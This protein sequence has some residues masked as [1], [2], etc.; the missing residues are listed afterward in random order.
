MNSASDRLGNSPLPPAAGLQAD[1]STHRADI[2]SKLNPFGSRRGL[3]TL[4]RP[5]VSRLG[6]SH[7]LGRLL[8]GRH[9]FAHLSSELLE[10]VTSKRLQRALRP[11]NIRG[12]SAADLRAAAAS[13][14]SASAATVTASPPTNTPSRTHTTPPQSRLHLR[15]GSRS[16]HHLHNPVLLIAAHL[17]KHHILKPPF[18]SLAP[19]SSTL[20][21]NVGGVSHASLP[22]PALDALGLQLQRSRMSLSTLLQLSMRLD[23]TTLPSFGLFPLLV[24][25][26][27]LRVLLEI[28]P[29]LKR[30]VLNTYEI[31]Q[32][33]GSGQH[34]KVD[35]AKD[36]LTN[37][38]VAI[39][40]IDR[41]GK[42]I[43]GRTLT[44]GNTPEDKVRREIAIMKKCLHP[45]I[46][47]LR[48][49]LDDTS[50]YKV[51]LVLE[52]CEGGEIAWEKNNVG[53]PALT[54]AKARLFFRDLVLGL[55]YLHFQGIIHRDIK[56][57]NMLLHANGAVKIS[58]FGVSFLSDLDAGFNEFELAKT[59][60]TPAF[61]A[62]ELCS[63]D[64]EGGP[65]ITYK[66]DIWS[67]GVTLYC[68]L[69][70]ELPF[71]A[72]LEFLL[73]DAIASNQVQF[74]ARPSGVSPEE[75]ADA[76]SLLTLLLDKNPDTRIT[77]KGVKLHPFMLRWMLQEQWTYFT[78]CN[79]ALEEGRIAVLNEEMES[80]VLKIGSK[81]KKSL[82]RAFI[83][84]AGLTP[85][86]TATTRAQLP[87]L[88]EVTGAH[89]GRAPATPRAKSPL[90]LLGTW[91]S[92][93]GRALAFGRPSAG[94]RP[95]GPA[96]FSGRTLPV[97][98]ATRPLPFARSG[99]APPAELVSGGSSESTVSTAV[100]LSASSGAPSVRTAAPLSQARVRADSRASAVSA[101]G[102]A[103]NPPSPGARLTLRMAALAAG[104]DDPVSPPLPAVDRSI[105]AVLVAGHTD[106]SSAPLVVQQPTPKKAF[107]LLVR[108][109]Q[110][111][112]VPSAGLDLDLDLDDGAFEFGGKGRAPVAFPR[113]PLLYRAYQLHDSLI[114]GVPVVAHRSAETADAMGEWLPL[115]ADLSQLVAGERTL[116]ADVAGL[117]ML[118]P[119]SKTS[120]RLFNGS[121]LTPDLT[122]LVVLDLL[123]AVGLLVA[124]DLLVAVEDTPLLVAVENTPL[125]VA[126]P[127]LL[128][129]PAVALLATAVLCE[130]TSLQASGSASLCTGSLKELVERVHSAMSELERARYRNHYDKP[131]HVRT[132]GL[133]LGTHLA[134]T[135]PSP[136]GRQRSGSITVGILQKPQG[137]KLGPFIFGDDLSDESE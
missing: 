10:L 15:S 85:T 64:S 130:R 76:C 71:N 75:Y 31:M 57:A 115:D 135:S 33:L 60:G 81:I 50:L 95:S 77:I 67:C 26:E 93:S 84:F 19:V 39:K 55:E 49:A 74:P 9:A 37:D 35:L 104:I 18:L 121:T 43:A 91:S 78:H 53:A 98:H 13:V 3:Q 32:E 30:K 111:V 87:L 86:P 88:K 21:V 11:H 118:H 128:V 14:A 83:R 12:S 105:S 54:F 5:S 48:E 8:L 68:L 82:A 28:D 123:V 34:G 122:G 59:A 80:A 99:S 106:T 110:P 36:L 132:T 131:R 72:D 101:G 70:G 65:K 96:F 24:V 108:F 22:Q 17:Q 137:T 127:V 45:H 6:L 56:P 38:L 112:R 44:P 61:Y 117:V 41:H 109:S 42:A 125:L 58:D 29:V 52:Y 69:F 16:S 113:R 129:P 116:T 124:L 89:A 7:L 133:T 25:K 136:M 126:L 102:V 103:S 92:Q 73:Y 90:Q 63:M 46:V 40:I 51:Y 20:P 23:I 47:Q 79:D 100:P 134:A 62:P 114:K 27:T 1:H 107:A 4:L 120:I 2:F 119:V 66:I 97:T 94:T